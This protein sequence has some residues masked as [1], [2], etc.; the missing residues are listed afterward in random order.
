MCT[1]HINF[2]PKGIHAKL[3]VSHQYLR[4]IGPTYAVIPEN[5][6]KEMFHIGCRIPLLRNDDSLYWR[7]CWYHMAVGC[8]D[9]GS[10]S[11][12]ELSWFDLSSPGYD[13]INKARRG[14]GNHALVNRSVLRQE[15]SRTACV[16]SHPCGRPRWSCEP[17]VE[18]PP[19]RWLWESIREAFSEATFVSFMVCLHCDF[20][21][22]VVGRLCS[23]I[24]VLSG[25]SL[26]MLVAS[27]TQG[28]F[29]K[30]VNSKRKEFATIGSKFFPFR[31]DPFSEGARLDPSHY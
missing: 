13:L 25:S 31:A 4:Q 1:I 22:D 14:W 12:H 21:L 23:V 2:I 3:S 20:P 5:H 6:M 24:V 8:S 18:R 16:S 15:T 29:W 28:F 11:S 9:V 26:V 30:W 27:Y 17:T 7:V 19:D 10:N